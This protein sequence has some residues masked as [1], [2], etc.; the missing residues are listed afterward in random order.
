MLRAH[1][2]LL[3]TAR[4]PISEAYGWLED[5][6]RRFTGEVLDVSQAVPG[7]PPALALRQHLSTFVL[8]GEASGY[9]PQLGVDSLRNAYADHLNA[10]YGGPVVATETGIVAGCNQAFC[11][12]VLSLCQPGDEVLLGVPYYFNHDMWLRALGMVPRYVALDPE[13]DPDVALELINK[14]TRALVVISPNNPTGHE[15]SP[16]SLLGCYNFAKQHGLTL[17]LDETYRD[18]R[19]RPDSTPHSLFQQPDWRDHLVQLYSFSKVY[20][21]AGYRVGALVASAQFLEQV[22]KLMDCVAI[23]AP[24]IAQEAAQF[25]LLN[26]H[27]WLTSKQELMNQRLEHFRELMARPE[28]AGQGWR[29]KRSGAYFA[30]LEH[31]MGESARN[32]ARVLA[33]EHGVLALSGDMFGPGQERY[34][35]FAFA[36]LSRDNFPELGRRLAGATREG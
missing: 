27:P 31:P 1:K 6:G 30:W 36:N 3:K 26:L 8:G 12:A 23:C 22:E 18:F 7:Y 21:L 5:D 25:G 34:L 17:L 35:R 29:V 14:K 10:L 19:A 32:A 9:T 28:L 13:F 11:L 4:S 20:C 24:R 15:S 33:Q 16:G 2:D